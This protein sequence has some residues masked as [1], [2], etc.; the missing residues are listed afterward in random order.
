M[1][2]IEILTKGSILVLCMVLLMGCGT[3][4][5][6]NGD[7]KTQNIEHRTSDSGTNPGEYTK[8]RAGNRRKSENTG[9]SAGGQFC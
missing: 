1:K 9:K 3:D 2:W 7:A 5:E 6:D 4:A 8:R